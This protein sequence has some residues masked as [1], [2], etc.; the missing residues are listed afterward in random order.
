MKLLLILNSLSIFSFNSK[1]VSSSF[2]C[3]INN[4][5][6]NDW[7]SKPEDSI[8]LAQFHPKSKTINFSDVHRF[9]TGNEEEIAKYS[10]EFIESI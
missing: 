9:V 10:K 2:P 6:D 3:V 1:A 7:F 8:K 4:E 5:Y